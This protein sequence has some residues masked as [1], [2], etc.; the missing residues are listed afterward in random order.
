MKSKTS[1]NVT[2]ITPYKAEQYQ[3]FIE[4]V[5]NGQIPEHWEILAEA[6]GVTRQTI[7]RWKEL[8]EFQEAMNRGIEECLEQMKF[9]GKKDWKMWRE[10]LALLRNEAG[11]AD[12]VINA[13]KV[14]AILGGQSVSDN[15]SN[16]EN[17]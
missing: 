2:K 16:Q 10:R 9:Y 7:A 8:P 1:Q 14:I 4:L 6:L 3:K 15:D 13:D 5:G 12:V 11:K 17:S